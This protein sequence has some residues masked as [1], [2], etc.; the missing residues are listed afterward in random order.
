M[1]TQ[2]HFGKSRNYELF[3]GEIAVDVAQ[4]RKIGH[5]QWAAEEYQ[6]LIAERL[7]DVRYIA[8]QIHERL[9]NHIPLE[10][11]VHAGIIGL[12]D[13]ARKFNA[14]KHVAF[15]TYAKFRIRGAIIDSMRE[16]D[17]GPRHLRRRHCQLEEVRHRLT[18]MLGRFPNDSELAGE[19][20]ISLKA[21]QVVMT[22]LNSL[23]VGSL[24]V[25]PFEGR[26]NAPGDSISEEE[27]LNPL[28][29][30]L[31][32]EKQQ[33]LSRALE[34]LSEIER[35]VLKLY[36]FEELTLKAV[37]A[38]LQ[39]SET[40]A[41][42]IRSAAIRTLRAR[43]SQLANRHSQSIVRCSNTQDRCVAAGAWVGR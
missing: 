7:H 18:A 26:D 5:G 35:R 10:D 28:I 14:D 40:R 3:R 31:N 12:I 2:L 41:S 33:L 20:G 27:E 42:Q 16:M 1:G 6:K 29:Q 11:L 36:Y 13:A 43:I 15:R 8:R 4:A 30:C 19:L 37:A 32:A 25:N 34:D 22:T 38:T 24:S 21:L 17:W 23:D 39:F 9:P